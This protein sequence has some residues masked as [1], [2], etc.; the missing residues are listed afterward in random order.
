MRKILS[1]LLLSLLLAIPQSHAQRIGGGNEIYFGPADSIYTTSSYP[2]WYLDGPTILIA[3]KFKALTTSEVTDVN[4]YLREAGDMSA[5]NL[6]IGIETDSGGSPDGTTLGAVTSAFAISASGW[7]GE[8]ALATATGALTLNQQYWMVISHDSGDDPTATNKVRFDRAT[9]ATDSGVMKRYDGASWATADN[10]HAMMVLKHADGTY[11]GYTS[12][13]AMTYS[14][15]G[16]FYS[17]ERAGFKFTLGSQFK[18]Q[19]CRFVTHKQGSPPALDVSIYTGDVLQYTT[20]IPAAAVASDGWTK[21]AFPSPALLAADT[22]HYVIF[23]C[24]SDAGD[25]GNYYNMRGQLVTTTYFSNLG[26]PTGFNYIYGTGVPSSLTEEVDF[27]GAFQFIISD[28][29]SDFD[30][31]AAGGGDSAVGYWSSG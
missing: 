17:T 21:V 18:V 27:W 28:F 24:A 1:F 19:G 14:S 30:Q 7:T 8:K 26:K 2:G 6:N 11:S 5:I 9:N 13:G 23:G 31:A 22:A 29:E 12:T 16:S 15:G 4:I 20:T 10:N 3:A 25:S